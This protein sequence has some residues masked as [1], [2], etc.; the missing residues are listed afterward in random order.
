MRTLVLCVGG[1]IPNGRSGGESS[2]TYGGENVHV[3]VYEGTASLVRLAH[4]TL[5]HASA[6]AIL[7]AYPFCEDD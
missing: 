2:D 3:R 7:H 6:F 1:Y 5:G 4:S